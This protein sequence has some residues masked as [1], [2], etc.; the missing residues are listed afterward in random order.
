MTE[1][2]RKQATVAV[3]LAIAETIKTAKQVPSGYLYARLMNA[4]SLEA[5]QTIIE[6]LKASGK[7]VEQGHLL[8]WVD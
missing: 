7:V 4:M 8:S 5:Y 2:K 6:I 3:V 1:A